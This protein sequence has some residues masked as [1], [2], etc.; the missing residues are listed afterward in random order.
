MS[1]KVIDINEWLRWVISLHPSQKQITTIKPYWKCKSKEDYLKVFK[2]DILNR[3]FN[4]PDIKEDEWVDGKYS[5][6]LDRLFDI[7][8][9]VPD[10]EQLAKVNIGYFTLQDTLDDEK[11]QGYIQVIKEYDKDIIDSK[12]TKTP[13]TFRIV[14]VDFGIFKMYA[15]QNRVLEG[16][17]RYVMYSNSKDSELEKQNKLHVY[18]DDMQCIFISI[19][20]I[21]INKDLIKGKSK[22]IELQEEKR[23]YCFNDNK[24]NKYQ[25][26][27][28]YYPEN[29]RTF[30]DY[31][32]DKKILPFSKSIRIWS[33][34]DYYEIYSD[35]KN[36]SFK[37]YMSEEEMLRYH[38]F[39][40]MNIKSK[41]ELKEYINDR[42]KKRAYEINRDIP[43][44]LTINY[45]INDIFHPIDLI[46]QNI[47][48]KFIAEMN[49][50]KL[51]EIIE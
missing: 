37:D 8:K 32:I 33:K 12:G 7:Y 39:P 16:E 6:D 26:P 19:P 15:R 3:Y 31:C 35:P 24:G 14:M 34:T 43:K 21:K 48:D 4:K 28:L 38:P 36:K 46:T 10:C 9:F 29:I 30:I 45:S 44:K 41:K 23:L 25:L 22:T 47:C 5:W 11:W 13:C 42:K 17:H 51:Y 20:G 50:S 27:E 2:K 49:N 1:N 40:M 18:W